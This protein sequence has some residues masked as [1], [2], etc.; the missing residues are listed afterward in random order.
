MK[1][2]RTPGILLS[3]LNRVISMA[4]NLI[5]TPLLIASLTEQDYSLYKVIQSFAGPLMM[6]NLGLSTITARAVAR[7]QGEPT[8]EN[9]R[10]QESTFAA[11]LLISLAMAT[12]SAGLGWVMTPLI[13]VL[14]GSTFSPGQLET[15]GTLLRIFSAATG[16]HIVS[17]TFGG[18]IQ[19]RERFLFFRGAVTAQ[20]MLRFL[21]LFCIARQISPSPV[22]LAMADLLLYGGILCAN[23]LYCLLALKERP[24]LSALRRKTLGP[25]FLFGLATLLQAV[26][27]QVNNNLDTV[28]LA[29]AGAAP[30]TITMY[31]AALT[32]FTMYESLVG[33]FST[34]YFPKA[35]QLTAADADG[36]ALTDFVI[37]PG[38]V[39]AK[40]ALAI[41][42]GFA[43][44]GRDFIRVWIG[45]QYMAAHS[46][47]L[48]LMAAVTIPMVQSVCV[49]LL[50]AKLKKLFR[51]LVLAGM[52]AG[53]LLVS[54]LLVKPLGYWGP[55]LATAASLVIGH[56][57]VMNRYYAR[58]LGLNIPRMLREIFSGGLLPAVASCLLCLP[59]Q[60]FPTTTFL[61]LVL[62]CATFLAVYLF[63]LWKG[64]CYERTRTQPPA[65]NAV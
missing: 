44:F 28:I 48:V 62:K 15:A 43:L 54:L 52:A 33:A 57:V 35:A 46:I 36:E 20:Y 16:L 4:S 31:T 60:L 58:N 27:S 8:P 47:A 26:I 25:I 7:Y 6:L 51:S 45:P 59:L 38:R 29:A 39:Q 65:G 19:G 11:A 55:A 32:I 41:L 2:Q 63:L 21:I 40:I 9:R 56:A 12:L 50:D 14:F 49:T 24:R 42:G 18:L 23:M 1:D 53:N 34:I 17:D 13:P 10:E 5:L 30:G 22:Q 37:A 61:I 3:Y 64:A